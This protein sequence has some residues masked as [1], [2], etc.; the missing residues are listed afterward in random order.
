M[1]LIVLVD[2]T[3]YYGPVVDWL[4]IYMII[5]DIIFYYGPIVGWLK[6]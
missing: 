5:L 3:F 6:I 2:I 4:K 1:D